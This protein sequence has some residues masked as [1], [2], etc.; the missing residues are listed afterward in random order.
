MQRPSTRLAGALS[1]VATGAGLATAFASEWW[2]GLVPCALCLW[3]RW[4]YRLAILLGI[5]AALLPPEPGLSLLAAIALVMLGAAALAMVH[6]G[7]EHAFWPSPLPECA[8]PRLGS[9][10][11]ADRLAAMPAHPSKPC[12]DPTYLL[13]GLPVSMAEM[14]LIYAL[15]ICLVLAI[16]VWRSL[17]EPR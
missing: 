16:Y 15:I 9:G 1:V 4:P 10:S 3:E 14:N 6:V 8:A 5:L 12:D 7:V 11:L 13:P 17:K 2:L